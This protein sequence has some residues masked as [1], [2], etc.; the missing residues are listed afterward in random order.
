MRAQVGEHRGLLRGGDLAGGDVGVETCLRVREDRRLEAGRG[1]T[2]R[3]RDLRERLLFI[4]PEEEMASIGINR[5]EGRVFGKH[6]VAKPFQFQFADDSFLQQT[7]EI[8]SRRYSVARPNCLRDRAPAEDLAPFEN[9]YLLSRTREVSG[10]DEAVMTAPNNYDVEFRGHWKAT[11][12]SGGSVI[13]IVYGRP[14]L[15]KLEDMTPP[16]LPMLLPP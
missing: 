10:S 4:L 2:L 7:D 15:L 16:P 5:E 3:G 11:T 1:L 6:L 8:G 13:E 14:W 9:Q 12:A